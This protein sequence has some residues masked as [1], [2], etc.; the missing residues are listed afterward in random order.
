MKVEQIKKIIEFLND[1]VEVFAP[2]YEIDEAN[3]HI[4]NNLCD[5]YKETADLTKE[6]W[7]QVVSKMQA[8]DGIWQA[9]DEAFRYYIEQVIQDRK[10]KANAN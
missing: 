2:F 4:E 6:E 9:L 1:D 5:G 8:D 7:A 3:E 10:E